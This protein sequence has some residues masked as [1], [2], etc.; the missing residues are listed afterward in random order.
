MKNYIER[1]TFSVI[2]LSILTMLTACGGDENKAK[3][4]TQPK[5]T[6]NAYYDQFDRKWYVSYND[7]R[8]CKQSNPNANNNW[9]NGWN[10]GH[11]NGN[12]NCPVGQVRVRVPRTGS[13]LGPGGQVDC[14]RQYCDNPRGNS[15]SF[16]SNNVHANVNINI[17]YN[18]Y[19][20]NQNSYI[21]ACVNRN[22]QF[23]VNTG[24]YWYYDIGTSYSHYTRGGRV[25]T[26]SNSSVN[27]FL[28]GVLG[29]LAGSMIY[30]SATR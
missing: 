13:H 27:G 11:I 23:V 4:T 29:G 24:F 2:L 18:N 9:N 8:E 6:D 26:A 20:R 19:H 28:W 7:D 15:P 1:I 21:Y 22:D 25:H 3:V 17:D 14:G 10:N 16:Y 30:N 12:L 5:C